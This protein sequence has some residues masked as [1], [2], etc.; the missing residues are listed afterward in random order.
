MQTDLLIYAILAAVLVV[1]LR[2]ILGTRD[3]DEQ[4]RPNPYVDAENKT[5]NI[6]GLDGQPFVVE[7]ENALKKLDVS[8]ELI[9]AAE[10]LNR[11]MR[12]F[13]ALKFVEN[14]KDA[15]VMVVEAFAKGE[16]DV[17]EM[18]LAPGVYKSFEA[19]L[20]E[21]E[22]KGET[23]STEIHA[24]R[25]ADLV[26][27]QQK[28]GMAYVSI[29]FTADE[30]CVIRDKDEKI[31]SGDPERITEMVDVWTFG[32]K[33]KSKEPTWLL[34]ETRDDEVEDHKTPIP[35]ASN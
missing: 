15:F 33:I 35:D 24:I 18:L 16:K 20:N 21:R 17:L 12:D 23:V 6:V 1:W 26:D 5:K 8:D 19:A 7:T 13:D 28:D 14:A 25:K 4:Q 2:N 29:R 9:A 10:Q 3:S 22:N 32:R 31:L 11:S 30:T 27:I 34:Y